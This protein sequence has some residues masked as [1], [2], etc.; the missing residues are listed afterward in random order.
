MIS[1][2]IWSNLSKKILLYDIRTVQCTHY[3]SWKRKSSSSNYVCR[4]HK[5][6]IH[7]KISYIACGEP[8]LILIFLFHFLYPCNFYFITFRHRT[9]LSLLP[10]YFCVLY[11]F[12]RLFDLLSMHSLIS[13]Y[14]FTPSSMLPLV[15]H[16]A[17]YCK[18]NIF[19]LNVIQESKW[20]SHVSGWWRTMV[21]NVNYRLLL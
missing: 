6:N 3:S 18:R 11:S 12:L 9:I 17:T 13:K 5:I 2:T 19:I 7:H 4:S 1:E 10:L 16:F 21:C 8:P 15:S 20:S 14:W